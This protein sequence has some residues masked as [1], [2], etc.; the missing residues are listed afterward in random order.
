MVELAKALL[1]LRGYIRY[2]M[3]SAGPF[4]GRIIVNF[5]TL[6]GSQTGGVRGEGRDVS[7]TRY[8]ALPGSAAAVARL[9]RRTLVDLKKSGVSDDLFP[10]LTRLC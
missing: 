10:S 9:G 4:Q 5:G 2:A 3:D 1:A 6:P 7:F 8:V